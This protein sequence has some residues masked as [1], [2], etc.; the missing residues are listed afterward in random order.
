VGGAT[1]VLDPEALRRSPDAFDGPC[2]VLI[3]EGAGHW[4]HREAP[5]MF[6]ERLL[7]F[8]R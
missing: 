8:L 5:D 7:A 3:A 1:D 2:D 6:E 4:A